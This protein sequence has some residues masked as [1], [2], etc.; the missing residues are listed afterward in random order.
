MNVNCENHAK[1]MEL[2]A[3]R[4]RLERGIFDSEELARV[5]ARIEIL[6]KE[7]GLD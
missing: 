1:A 7:L 6:E 3:L 2:L 5:K 4:L